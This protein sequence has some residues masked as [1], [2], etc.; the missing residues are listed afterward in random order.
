MKRSRTLFVSIAFALIWFSAVRT[1][2]Q[3][4]P[5][6]L[7]EFFNSVDI[8]SVEVSP[9][10]N[11]VVIA[12]EQA[13]WESNRW[14]DD[15][16]LYRVEGD[17]GGTLI[18]LTQSGH[19]SDPRWS[20][21]GR[22]VAFLSDRHLP[23]PAGETGLPSQDVTQVYV[24]SAFGGEAF[25][26]TWGDEETHSFAW[27][28]DSRTIYFSSCEPWSK[29]RVDEYQKVWKDV[30]RLRESERGDSIRSV[31]LAKVLANGV[32]TAKPDHFF[33]SVAALPYRVSEL[34]VSPDGR[35]LAIATTPPSERQENMEAYAIYLVDVPGGE[36]RLLSRT[37][38]VYENL[39]WAPDSRHIFF[40]VELGTIE[41]PYRDLQPRI[42]W[43]EVSTGTLERWGAQFSGALTS[44][45]V[46]PTGSLFAAGRLGTQ[47]AAYQ[48]K[49]LKDRLA[50]VPSWPGTYERLS[51]ATQSSRVAFVYST[52]QKPAEVYL[53]ESSEKLDQARPITSFNR[54]FTERALPQGKPYR[55]TS[56][57]GTTVEG[58]L[59][60]PP[61]KFG[62]TGLPMFT[63]I[64]GGPSDADGDHFEFD[65]YQWG[66]LAATEGWLVFEPN[67]RGSTGYGDKFAL[68]VAPHLV[69]VPSKDILAGV[70]ALVKDGVADPDRLTI[71]GYSYGGYL[72]NWLITQTTRFK[73]A[74]TGAGAVE[75]VADWGNDDVS[76]DDIFFLGGPPWEQKETYNA[77]AAIWQI[78]KVK[79]PTHVVAGDD[80]DRVPTLEAYILERALSTLGVPTTL[81]ILPGEDHS[82]DKNPWHGK[83]KVREELKWLQKYG[84][85]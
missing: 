5:V 43:V 60:Y 80:D 28:A 42:Y 73:A 4:P 39:R 27:S 7:E 33:S 37:M 17:S 34:A 16:W 58:M 25:P 15:L 8:R 52:L 35:R 71:G 47:I 68:E 59:I 32:H 66:S 11:A 48:Q 26:V 54:L 67:Y 57:D 49:N 20:P 70:D 12:T 50:P 14:R 29:E 1:Y 6:T 23:R 40:W 55:W 69:S 61:G 76:Y 64:H 38:A 21:D 22:W 72:T 83:I 78:N 41:G 10:G 62:A 81:L 36:P 44:F 24:I 13:D 65:W 85:R 9:D 31:E 51:A 82:L 56:F 75:H 3:K 18:A 84:G 77:E 45:D 79:T 46:Q 30:I 74:V 2:A 63:L 53:A 19:G